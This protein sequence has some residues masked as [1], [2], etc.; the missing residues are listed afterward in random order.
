VLGR[1]RVR[2]CARGAV[3]LK[4]QAGV[5]T[6]GL[7]VLWVVALVA[8]VAWMVAVLGGGISTALLWPLVLIIVSTAAAVPA[9]ISAVQNVWTIGTVQLKDGVA[10]AEYLGPGKLPDVKVDATGPVKVETRPGSSKRTL[11]RVV[12]PVAG[13]ETVVLGPWLPPGEASRMAE[14]LN[15]THTA[16]RSMR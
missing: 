13:G 5:L 3:E 8:A 11:R 7:L 9:L 2:A 4:W 6:W 15:R 10:D 16:K 14:C 12:A 1:W